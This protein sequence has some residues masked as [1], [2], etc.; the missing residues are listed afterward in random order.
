MLSS[1][2][3]NIIVPPY[4]VDLLVGCAFLWIACSLKYMTLVYDLDDSSIFNTDFFIGVS[5][6]LIIKTCFHYSIHSDGIKVRFLWVPIRLI[7]WEQV[8][9]AEYVYRWHTGAKG[10]K[11]TGQGIFVTLRGCPYF[12]PEIDALN[13]FTLRHPLGSFF[14]RFTPKYQKRYV[15]IFSHYFPRLD[16]QIGYESNLKKG[17][18]HS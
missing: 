17:Q 14:I 2:K 11:M 6:L 3:K 12:C 9:H 13:M 1:V 8:A 4:W 7:K 16:Y 18:K 10:A 5:V 15:D